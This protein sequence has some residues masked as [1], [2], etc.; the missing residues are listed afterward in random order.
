M[1]IPGARIE[2]AFDADRGAGNRVDS[3]PSP[4]RTRSTPRCRAICTAIRPTPLAAEWISTRSERLTPPA[5]TRLCQAVAK[6]LGNVTAPS[7]SSPSGTGTTAA[8]LATTASAKL[9]HARPRTRSPGRRP[10][11][12]GPTRAMR[13]QNSSPSGP[14]SPEAPQ[15]VEHVAEVQRRRLDIDLHLAGERVAPHDPPVFQMVDGTAGADR[16]PSRSGLRQGDRHDASHVAIAAPEGEIVPA[17]GGEQL[18][19]ERPDRFT[20]AV[21][22]DAD[23]TEIRVLERRRASE[24]P[25]GGLGEPLAQVA[26]TRP[27]RVPGDQPDLAGGLGGTPDD[28]GAMRQA[29]DAAPVGSAPLSQTASAASRTT[30]SSGAISTSPGQ[31]CAGIN[32]DGAPR[33]DSS[34]RRAAAAPAGSPTTRQRPARRAAGRRRRGRSPSET[35]RSTARRTGA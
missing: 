5:T 3:L 33:Q 23:A 32:A 2:H 29:S 25:D 19:R 6:A 11:T 22:V 16:Q 28:R 15:H 4:W 21:Q 34:S 13:P 31:A 10:W 35:R 26:L 24:P 8:A 18:G 30:R 17:R 1:R 20:A 14:G 12:S 7:R 27:L 9:P